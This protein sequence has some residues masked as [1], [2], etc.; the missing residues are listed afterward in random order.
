MKN[1]I[2]TLSFILAV[3]HPGANVARAE[4]N[5]NAAKTILVTGATGTQGGAVARALLQ[6]GYAVRG[7]TRYPDSPRAQALSELGAVMVRG[8]FNDP[9]SLAAAMNGAHGVFAVT[10]FWEHGY[11][12]EVDHGRWLIEASEKAGI[13][14]FVY[15]SVAGAQNHTG[16]PHFDS[17]REVERLLTQSTLIWSVVGPVEFMDNWRWSVAEFQGGQFVDPRDDDSRHQWIAASDIG[18]FV[19]EA[20]DDVD[21]WAGKRLDIASDEMT[22]GEFAAAMSHQLGIEVKHVQL[23]W[24]EFEKAAGEEITLMVRWFDE[25]GYSADIHALKKGN[26]DL[27][28]VEQFLAG[29]TWPAAR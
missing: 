22:M 24:E 23:G 29:M 25:V 19:A 27:V 17:K 26:P 21:E 10:D 3:T 11:E 18:Y 8:N 9:E 20:F 15:T 5:A 2:L 13:Q 1:L 14:H 16:I 28:T 7:L 6:K 12:G 4:T